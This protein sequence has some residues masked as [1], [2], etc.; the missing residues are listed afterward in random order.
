MMLWLK[1]YHPSPHKRLRFK[2]KEDR[3]ENIKEMHFSRTCP[4]AMTLLCEMLQKI[5]KIPFNPDHS[6]KSSEK[7]CPKYKIAP[8]YF[9]H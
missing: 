8:K 9:C 1:D 6:F 5:F 7:N 3:R 4:K 2:E